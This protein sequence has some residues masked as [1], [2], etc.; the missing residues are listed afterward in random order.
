MAYRAS[1][2]SAAVSRPSMS[3][4]TVSQSLCGCPRRTEPRDLTG[5]NRD[6]RDGNENSVPGACSRHVGV[7]SGSISKKQT[8]ENHE[9]AAK[10]SLL[11]PT[12]AGFQ[13]ACKCHEPFLP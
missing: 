9:R 4:A 5:G 2:S 12:V 11:L 1:K 6:N 13:V 7:T 8:N 3:G 10:S